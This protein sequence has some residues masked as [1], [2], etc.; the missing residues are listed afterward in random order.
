MDRETLME[1]IRSGPIEVT[2]NDGQTYTIESPEFCIVDD[3]AAHVL[4]QRED[5]SWKAKIL[6]LVCMTS[7]T[8]PASRAR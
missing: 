2:M 1:A 7:I 5:G 6:S 8:P 3:I 4:T